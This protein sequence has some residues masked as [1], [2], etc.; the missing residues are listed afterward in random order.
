[1]PPAPCG[2]RP[3]QVLV[4]H[5]QPIMRLGLRSVIEREPA[6]AVCAEAGL[7]SEALRAAEALAPRVVLA[8]FGIACVEGVELIREMKR[9]S[10]ETRALVLGAHEEC[11]LAER[12]LRS[13]ANG[14]LMHKAAPG[15]LVKA[16][17][18]VMAGEL[19][20]SE[21]ARRKMLRKF[22]QTDVETDSRPEDL[23]T[24]R[25][26]QVFRMLGQGE[27]T[28]EIAENLALSAKTVSTYRE[29]IKRKLNIQSSTEIVR[30]AALWTMGCE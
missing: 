22:V 14:Y 27:N 2:E 10:P 1:M 30:Q 5:G 15:E 24:A 23:L 28:K 9:V 3:I 19:V 26:L 20:L 17:H 7:P 16:I 18:R 4:V 29:R 8:D 25:E 11:S 12:A 21:E 13:G 6:M